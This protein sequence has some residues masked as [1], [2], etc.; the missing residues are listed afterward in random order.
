MDDD[1]DDFRDLNIKTASKEKMSKYFGSAAISTFKPRRLALRSTNKIKLSQTTQK[2]QNT[3]PISEEI[4]TIKDDREKIERAEEKEDIPPTQAFPLEEPF[5]GEEAKC[6]LEVTPSSIKILRED[7]NSQETSP[8]LHL[9]QNSKR[10]YDIRA[11]EDIASQDAMD[12]IPAT[13]AL[14]AQSAKALAPSCPTN[15]HSIQ[16]QAI[17]ICPICQCPLVAFQ[18]IQA[19]EDHMADI[20]STV[21]LDTNAVERCLI[22]QENISFMNEDRK[23]LHINA[24]LDSKHHIIPA[25]PK[26]TETNTDATSVKTSEVYNTGIHYARMLHLKCCAKLRKLTYSQLIIQMNQLGVEQNWVNQSPTPAIEQVAFLEADE[27]FTEDVVIQPL[28]NVVLH[29]P[30]R[31][32]PE[33]DE[34]LQYALAMSTSLYQDHQDVYVPKQKRKRLHADRIPTRI[35][36]PVEAI[37]YLQLKAESW[38]VKSNSTHKPSGRKKDRDLKWWNLQACGPDMPSDATFTT[39][40]FQKVL[41]RETPI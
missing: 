20:D 41:D 40:F 9:D 11:T 16:E 36:P 8:P 30:R 13:I 14:E 22:C 26:S 15:D 33:S 34:D 27:D 31:I 18:S 23:S 2:P 19:K 24:C 25:K 28:P 4:E 7:R 38:L 5:I 37:A 10:L 35:L 1:D 39:D 32:K 12:D 3:P 21:L 29:K 6:R 17:E